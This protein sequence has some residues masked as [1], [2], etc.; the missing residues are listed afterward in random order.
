MPKFI[1][2]ELKSDSDLDSDL[3]S[4]SYLDL[5]DKELMAKLKKLD[6]DSDSNSEKKLNSHSNINDVIRPVLNFLYFYD[7]ISQVQKSIKT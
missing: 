4:D 6:I 7:K 1:K 2:N 3:D 5:D